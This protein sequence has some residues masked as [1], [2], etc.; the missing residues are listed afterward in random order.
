MKKLFMLV[1][2]A[3]AAATTSFAQSTSANN[4]LYETDR[5]PAAGIA[6]NMKYKQIKSLYDYKEYTSTL[7]DR[8]NPGWSGAASFFIPGLGQMICGEVGRGFA[9]L[10][11]SVGC[12]IVATVGSVLSA[13]G[14]KG[15]AVTC[16]LASAG[17]LAIDICAI[18]DGVRVAKVKNM[19]EQDLRKTYA[20]DV[21]L[22]PSVN[23]IQTACGVQPTA[24]LTLAL[25]F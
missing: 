5:E 2:I 24:G 6:P 23:Y 21:D 25:K 1:A 3:F 4:K 13:Y 15:G 18:V 12:S 9:W 14:S 22:Y 7:D 16:L 8:Y 10:G 11:G 20:F 19:Y 17:V